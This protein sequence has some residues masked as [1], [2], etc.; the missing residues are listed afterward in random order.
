MKQVN[1]FT[2]I[3]IAAILTACGGGGGG[4]S[5]NNE[6][7]GSDGGNSGIEK[8]TTPPVSNNE[9]PMQPTESTYVDSQR[10]VIFDTIN[11]YRTTCGFSAIRQNSLT[12]T[13]A[14]GHSNYL[15]KNQA[16][17]HIQSSS[18]VGFTGASLKDRALNAGYQWK[19]LGEIANTRNSGSLISGTSPSGIETSDTASS[20]KEMINRLF[21]T[22]YHLAVATDEW[23]EMGVGLS[24]S[25]NLTPVIGKTLFY[26][27]SV[28]NFGVPSGSDQPLYKGGKVR[29]F[30]CEGVNGV[31]P[32]FT[33]ELPSPYPSRNFDTD[34]MGTPIGF[35][36]KDQS[37]LVIQNAT[38]T[39]VGTGTS[40]A[41]KIFNSKDDP[42]A[43]LK[44]SQAFV[45][46]EKPLEP[47]TS[48]KVTASGTD[49]NNSFQYSFIFKTGSQN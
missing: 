25:A 36:S 5:G 31:S 23:S 7:S 15:E 27:S 9:Y 20:G 19:M 1:K 11:S 16:S 28:V 47:N 48:Y 13:A 4:E 8:P 24:Q 22:V 35:V 26:T 39:D 40:L 34:P 32:I 17:G 43:T 38:Y 46:P 18:N 6:N 37:A 44:D 42:H 3:A 45:I 29:S 33:A 2:I 14:Q 49:G 21:S 12:D 30:P 41:V 10:K